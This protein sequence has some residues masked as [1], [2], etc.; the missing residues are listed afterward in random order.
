M[1]DKTPQVV[2]RYLSSLQLLGN[3]SLDQRA[4]REGN[5]KLRFT[6]ILFCTASGTPAEAVQCGQDLEISV[7][8]R[9]DEDTFY[10]VS[11][12]IGVYTLAGQCMLILSNE[13]VGT[14]FDLVP[15]RGQFSCLVR[16]LPL[17]PG[18][19]YLNVYCTVNGVLADWVQQAA[20]LMVEAGDFF[21]T[22]RLPP[23][24]HGGMLV[25]QDWRVKNMQGESPVR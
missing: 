7:A 12:S 17:T 24:T 16:R 22:G 4:D 13:M 2:Q 21:G 18:Q 5:G 23:Q 8:Y 9:G 3:H 25:T 10:R 11:M 1:N 19:Y 6:D 15:S 20:H 14:E